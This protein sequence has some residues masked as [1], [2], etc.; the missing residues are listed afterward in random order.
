MAGF[1]PFKKFRVYQKHALAALG[2]MAMISFVILPSYFMLSDRS[3]NR[4]QENLIASCRR[5]GYGNVDQ[6]MLHNNLIP[7]RRTLIDFYFN[8]FRNLDPLGQ[9]STGRFRPFAEMIGQMQSEFQSSEALI[10]D[11]LLA[12]YAQE[13]GVEITDELIKNHLNLITDNAVSTAIF[14]NA[15]ENT[16]ITERQALMLIREYL[17]ASSMKGMFLNSISPVSPLSR[18]D[19]YQRTNR[20]LTAEVAAVPVEKFIDKIK[21]PS[22]KELKTFFD[23]HKD[24]VY[25]PSFSETGFA[26]PARIA[27]QVIDSQPTQEMLDSIT[28]EEVK[29]FYEENKAQLFMRRQEPL[30]S[31][32][33]VPGGAASGLPSGFGSSLFPTSPGGGLEASGFDLL[34][35]PEITAPMGPVILPETETP[36]SIPD[37]VPDSI[38]DTTEESV[39]PQ[40]EDT[41]NSET[42]E[43]PQPDSLSGFEQPSLFRNVVFQSE[44]EVENVLPEP[45]IVELP[46]PEVPQEE[47]EPLPV[48]PPQEPVVE[49]VVVEGGIGEEIVPEIPNAEES[50]PSGESSDAATTENAVPET[51]EDIGNVLGGDFDP[52]TEDGDISVL[53]QPLSE[54]ESTIRQFLAH[55]KVQNAL[56][57]VQGKMEAFS[58]AYTL[59]DEKEGGNALQPPD[60]E[61]LATELNLRI[62]TESQ[63]LS[64]FEV[65][66]KAYFDDLTVRQ[67]LGQV[68]RSD[69][70]NFEVVLG[71]EDSYFTQ[72][73]PRLM[74]VGWVI[75]RHSKHVPEFSEEGIPALVEKR[76]LEIHAKELAQKHAEELANLANESRDK[77]LKELFADQDLKIVETERFSWLRQTFA[78]FGTSDDTPYPLGTVNEKG[79]EV[80]LFGDAKNRV[81]VAPG[82]G[83]METAYSLQIGESGV[84]MNQPETVVYVIRVLDSSPS[85]NILWEPFTGSARTYNF[86]KAGLRTARQKAVRSW[87]ESI[88]KAVG[89]RWE[90]RPQSFLQTE[91]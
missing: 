18:W 75:E 55:D 82:E 24:Q 65:L 43:T 52:T 3:G 10:I 50:T 32:Q 12:R 71:K 72:S 40:S 59:Y 87:V 68:F 33:G 17:L 36:D 29:N 91:D 78:S 28:P 90:N 15:C 21:S 26:I 2:I 39:P 56:K 81:L 63:P 83:F 73:E 69:S 27:F 22:E 16:G 47:S 23:R 19:Y 31:P 76:W 35:N 80:S 38:P 79:A 67:F 64:R 25:N 9:D 88:E 30:P 77:S 54:V 85:E 7:S 13:K 45:V 53:Y 14:F 58:T 61:T 42:P 48:E 37:S 20:F 6:I 84:A 46:T 5:S 49:K 60:L 74:Y 44:I 86:E 89:F 62:T 11:W 57:E 41:E 66:D 8:L 4:T 51:G 34:L 1:N 70:H